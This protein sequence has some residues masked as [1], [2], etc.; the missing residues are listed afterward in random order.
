MTLPLGLILKTVRFFQN[1]F[2]KRKNQTIFK[3]ENNNQTEFNLHYQDLLF[4]QNFTHFPPFYQFINQFFHLSALFMQF[5][6]ILNLFNSVTTKTPLIS[7][8]LG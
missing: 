5:K 7:S 2:D 6:F 3:T 4:T 1:N 8:A